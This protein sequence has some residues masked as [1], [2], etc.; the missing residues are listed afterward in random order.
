[1]SQPS[2]SVTK[3]GAAQSPTPGSTSS[4]GSKP[5]RPGGHGKLAEDDVLLIMKTGGTTMYHRLLVHLVTSLSPERINASNVVI[6]SD[7]AET[8]GNFTTLDVLANVTAATQSHPDFDVYHAMPQYVA[9]NVYPESARLEGDDAGPDG[10]WVLDKYKFLPLLDHAGKNWPRARWYVY[11]E[12][13]TYIFLPNLLA[14]L[15]S[16]DWTAP[17]YLGSTAFKAGVTFAHGGSG[18]ALSRGAWEKSFGQNP[19]LV[20][21]FDEY[22]HQHGCGDHILGR[23]LN[24]YGVRFGENGG[25]EKFSWGFNGIVHWRFAFKRANWCS[26]LLSWHKVHSRDVARYYELEKTWDYQMPM[27]HGD[28]FKRMIAPNLDKRREWWDNKSSLFEITSANADSPPAPQSGYNTSL[29]AHAW[30]S[31]D[32][33][34]AACE[35]WDECMQWSYYDD[36]CR[37]D[38][39]LTM[40]SGYAPGM[41]Q[42]KTGL[43]ITSGWFID[44]LQTW[45]CN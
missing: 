35:S 11:M 4:D 20:E 34:E 45:T 37:L 19:R 43:M 39:K 8:I 25:D 5:T 6:Y 44:R 26:P 33:C 30:K 1:M 27:L 42:R 38:D 9:N 3:S 23:A 36:L 31:V 18:F 13:D 14:Y 2:A 41:I 29:W 17:H 10:G 21:D 7:Y 22:T 40:G 16:F 24:E 12:D 15:S 28:F 32:A